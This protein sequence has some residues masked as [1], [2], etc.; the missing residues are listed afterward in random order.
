M[1]VEEIAEIPLSRRVGPMVVSERTGVPYKHRKFAETW[2]RVAN[3]AGIP[4]GVWNMDARSG[5]ISELY[6]AGASPTDAMKHAGHQDP[7]MSARYN[8]GSLEQTRRAARQ[9]LAK[10]I[11]N[12]NAGRD[13]DV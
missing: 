3:V 9:R 12:K 8:R 4:R 10:R 5:A 6:D 13:G 7:R 2:R 1:V 11:K